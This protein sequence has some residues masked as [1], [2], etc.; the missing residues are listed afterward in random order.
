MTIWRMR[1]ACWIPKGTDTYSEYVII[2]IPFPYQPR[3]HERALN[4]LDRLSK[5]L[6][7]HENPSSGSPFVPHGRTDRT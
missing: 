5:T 7:F 2:I 6:K 1:I 4:F 3:L